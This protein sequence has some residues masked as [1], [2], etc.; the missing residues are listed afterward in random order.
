[1]ANILWKTPQIFGPP[2]HASIY[3]HVKREVLH[4]HI[5]QNKRL[6]IILFSYE[7]TIKLLNIYLLKLKNR[8][9]YLFGPLLTCFYQFSAREVLYVGYNELL[10]WSKILGT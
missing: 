9:Y 10:F 6:I 3:F 7:Y 8:K 1:M 2:H 4:A 5:V